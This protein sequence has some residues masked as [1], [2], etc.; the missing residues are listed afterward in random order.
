MDET[1]IDQELE[2]AI[3]L[4]RLDALDRIYS[5]QSRPRFGKRNNDM[6]NIIENKEIN[7]GEVGIEFEDLSFEQNKKFFSFKD[8]WQAHSQLGER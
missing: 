4:L 8:E 6:H 3:A 7:D 5:R 2:A 1:L